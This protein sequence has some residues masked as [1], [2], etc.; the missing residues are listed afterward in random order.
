MTMLK[1]VLLAV[2][3]L[4]TVVGALL[5]GL[6]D[7]VPPRFIQAN[8]ILIICCTFVLTARALKFRFAGTRK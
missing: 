4:V 5:E 6:L 1:K 7:P 3:V 8:G 2:L